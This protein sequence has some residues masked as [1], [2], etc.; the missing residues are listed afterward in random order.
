MIDPF[1][2]KSQYEKTGM[3]REFTEIYTAVCKI[4][5]NFKSKRADKLI[6]FDDFISL[7]FCYLFMQQSK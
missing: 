4:A 6:S 5:K 7:L 1:A 2:L 3:D